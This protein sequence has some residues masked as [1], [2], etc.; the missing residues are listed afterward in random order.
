MRLTNSRIP[1]SSKQAPVWKTAIVPLLAAAALA[2]TPPPSF[3]V[4]S[5]KPNTIG[6]NGGR[7]RG[8]GSEITRTSPVSLTMQNIRLSSAIAWA[9]DVKDYQVSG[10]AWVDEERYDIAAKAAA[11]CSDSNLKLMLRSLL[12]ER[13]GLA[14]HRETKELPVYVLLIAKGGIKFHES[15]SVGEMQLTPVRGRMSVDVQRASVSEAVDLLSKPLRRPVLDMTGL[16]GRYDL[17]LDLAPYLS[18][19]EPGAGVTR[20]VGIAEVE[21]VLITA[22]QDQLGLKLEPRKAPIDLLVIDHA[23]K[24]PVEN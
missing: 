13:F 4:A 23:E 6:T 21:S 20:P 22:I 17:K 7:G 12:A 5:V 2:Q 16:T 1:A 8:R 24:V 11:P 18:D 3:D 9:Y 15:A 19:Q 14:F 10:P